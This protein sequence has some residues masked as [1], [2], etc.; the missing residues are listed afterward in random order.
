MSKR[1]R[2]AGSAL[3]AL[4]VCTAPPLTAQSLD[5][6][7]RRFGLSGHAEKAARAARGAPAPDLRRPR[8]SAAGTG[9]RRADLDSARSDAGSAGP[10]HR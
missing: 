6:L 5:E 1:Y 10:R 8:Q 4:L 3:A 7:E 9:I 2:F